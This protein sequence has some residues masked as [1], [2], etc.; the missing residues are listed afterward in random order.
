MV[1]LGL[2]LGVDRVRG[3]RV[4]PSYDAA[5]AALFARITVQPDA[6]RKALINSTIVALKAAGVW[7][8]L[9]YIHFEAAADAQ[10]SL[11]NWKSASFNLLAV[12]SPTFTADRGYAGDGTTSFLN[13]QFNPA[14]AGGQ[15][16]LNSASIGVYNRTTRAASNVL[17]AAGSGSNMIVYPRQGG[18]ICTVRLNDL[19]AGVSNANSFGLISGSRVVSTD[20]NTYRNGASIGNTV[21][22]STSL[23]SQP[24]YICG[25]NNSGTLTQ[26]STDQFACSY[27]GGGLDATQN[28]AL[29]SAIQAYMTGVGANV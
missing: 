3:R 29:Y 22:A 10:S 27:A 5:A 25:F 19:G 11:L 20:R 6:V 15:F 2:G 18:D 26:A 17:S 24:V 16:T 28:A 8:L 21:V 13:T 7:T 14:T 12:N 1:G 9:D 4:G 23:T